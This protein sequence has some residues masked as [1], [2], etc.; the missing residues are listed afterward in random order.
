VIIEA[1]ASATARAAPGARREGLVHGQ[2]AIIGRWL[3]HRAAWRGHLENCRRFILASAE[4]CAGRSCAVVLGSGPL[5][6][7]PL[8]A[9]AARFRRVVLIDAVQPLHA[10]LLAARL[11]NVEPR[12]AMLVEQAAAGPRYRS[13][14]DSA[15]SP[16]LVVASMLL[17]QLP[18]RDDADEA[19]RHAI[20]ADALEDLAAGTGTAC[21]ISETSRLHRDRTGA[22]VARADPLHGVAL[23]AAG[24]RWTWTM[25]P[26]GELLPDRSVELDVVACEVP[27][28]GAPPSGG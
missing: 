26:P 27:R 20:V 24:A 8:T 23:P 19:A 1:L 22:V 11:G 10:R 14:R 3:R 25:A 6:D 13:W 5:L 2:A 28:A 17:S 18:L 4:R 9:L 21:V 7:V 15:P 16:D 12:C